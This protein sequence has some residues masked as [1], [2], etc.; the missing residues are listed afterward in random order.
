MNEKFI[1]FPKNGPPQV[2]T[3]AG[4]WTLD[5][6]VELAGSSSD[7]DVAEGRFQFYPARRCQPYTPELWDACVRWMSKKDLLKAEYEQLMKKGVQ[8]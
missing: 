1:F 5:D 2:V 6:I 3:I 4:T 7:K 8:S